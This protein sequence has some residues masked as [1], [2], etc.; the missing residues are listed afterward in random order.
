MMS[1]QIRMIPRQPEDPTVCNWCKKKLAPEDVDGEYPPLCG[2]CLTMICREQRP[3][4]GRPCGIRPSGLRRPRR[5]AGRG[6][7]Q[8]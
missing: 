3:Y 7:A 8:G 5:T 2:P 6:N 4:R 1:E